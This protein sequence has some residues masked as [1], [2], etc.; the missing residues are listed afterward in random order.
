MIILILC[1]SWQILCLPVFVLVAK[2][3]WIPRYPKVLDHIS[4]GKTF[5]AT[6]ASDL[7]DPLGFE[8][9]TWKHAGEAHEAGGGGSNDPIS[10]NVETVEIC[11]M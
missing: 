5:G 4:T 2:S 7:P 11:D 9:L 10:V 1:R 8:E 6:K 3:R